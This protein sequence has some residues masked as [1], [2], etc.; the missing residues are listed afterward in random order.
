MGILKSRI[1]KWNK[2]K[3]QHANSKRNESNKKKKPLNHVL[4]AGIMFPK[5]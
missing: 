3:D 2:I 4:R 1:A 5:F